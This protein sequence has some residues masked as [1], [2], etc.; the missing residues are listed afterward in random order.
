MNKSRYHDWEFRFLSESL[1]SEI[2]QSWCLFSRIL[3]LKSLRGCKVRD[4]GGVNARLGD[5]SWNRI[6]Y[7]AS[8]AVRRRNVTPAGHHSFKMRQEL[9]WGDPNVFIQAVQHFSPPN[10]AAL[11]SAYGMPLD[12]IK[13]LQK[14]RNSCAH[15][16]IE[17]ILELRTL[18]SIY[19]F[20]N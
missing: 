16:N 10:Q 18:N 17:N 11:L 1:L 13:H 5:N 3:L 7:E 9:T 12:G 8:Y 14:V 2:W 4:G 20:S 6:C 19:D 15:K